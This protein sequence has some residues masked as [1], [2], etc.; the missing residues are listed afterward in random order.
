M[1]R[2]ANRIYHLEEP[3]KEEF[4]INEVKTRLD[5]DAPE[6][7]DELA[8]L[9]KVIAADDWSESNKMKFREYWKYL[10]DI[11]DNDEMLFFREDRLFPRRG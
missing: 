8:D 11:A 10:S 2:S 9:V 1:S 7:G 4:V 3:L 5:E 6:Y